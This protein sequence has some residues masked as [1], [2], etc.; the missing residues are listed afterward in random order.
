MLRIFS[1]YVSRRTLFFLV[2]DTALMT[3]CIPLAYRLRYSNDLESF[4][5]YT[6]LP[7]FAY[8]VFAVVGCF[9]V[10]AYY[11]ELYDARAE[12]NISDQFFRLSQA[13]GFGC[14]VLASVY[15][16]SPA[17]RIGRSTFALSLAMILVSV[18][19]LRWLANSI[20]QRASA[21]TNIARRSVSPRAVVTIDSSTSRQITRRRHA[22]PGARLAPHPGRFEYRNERINDLIERPRGQAFNQCFRQVLSPS[23]DQTRLPIA[24]RF[25]TGAPGAGRCTSST[26]AAPPRA[27]RR[28]RSARAIP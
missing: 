7:D 4:R 2:A 9:Q 25:E 10:C 16:V 6:A 15:F 22:A 17:L 5:Y 11:N 14:F 26:A 12:W 23:I 28:T 13:L 18:T 21:T 1:Q 20:W 27:G 8:Q 19:A 3:A 24:G